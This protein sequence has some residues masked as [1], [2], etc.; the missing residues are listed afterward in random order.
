[1]ETIKAGLQSCDELNIAMKE[2]DLE[3]SSRI[4]A[5]LSELS[6]ELPQSGDPEAFVMF[7]LSEALRD[8]NLH[9]AGLAVHAFVVMLAEEA[10]ASPPKMTR[11]FSALTEAVSHSMSPTMPA[12]RPRSSHL[13]SLFLMSYSPPRVVMV[14]AVAFS[15]RN[16]DAQRDHDHGERGG[17]KARS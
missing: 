3:L 17:S 5:Q 4:A 7:T 9:T 1:M 15:R 10:E 16:R 14:M 8:G 12:S 2:G 13:S 6:K 11:L